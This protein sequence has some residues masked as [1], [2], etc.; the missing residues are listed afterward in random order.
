VRRAA[1]SETVVSQAAITELVSIYR[2][3]LLARLRYW[4]NRWSAP[5]D[6]AE[7]AFQEFV[8]RK[9]LTK[10]LAKSFD[11]QLKFRTLLL[12]ALDRFAK[13][14][15]RKRLAKKRNPDG[16]FVELDDAQASTTESVH[17]GDL[18]WAHTVIQQALERV[19]SESERAGQE[20]YWGIFET[21]VVIP[22]MV[23]TPPPNYKTLVQR[24]GFQ[25]PNEAS[26]ALLTTTRRFRRAVESVVREYA[27][28]KEQAAMEIESLR[29]ILRESEA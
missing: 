20:A 11:P 25:T 5:E 3:A 23:G 8:E 26:N 1:A 2:P 18:E 29:E 14:W 17:A 15:I 16:G 7:D 27:P 28:G 4:L 21:R 10:T 19:K 12:T 9:I 6:E 13:T 22:S 24:F